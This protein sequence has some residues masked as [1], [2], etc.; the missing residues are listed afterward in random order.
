[1]PAAGGIL[2]LDLSLT[3]G[4][5]YGCLGQRPIWGVWPLGV[6]ARSGEALAVLEDHCDD[7][8]KLHRPGALVYEAPVPANRSKNGA[9]TIELLLQLCGIAKLIAVRHGI[10]YFHQHCGEARKAVLGR[11]PKGPSATIKPIIIDWARRRGWDLRGLVVGGE[12]IGVDDE[13]DALLLLQYAAVTR[14]RTGRAHFFK[15][16][17]LL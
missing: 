3:T 16:G 5:G 8:I 4:W 9:D 10:P 15:Q 11:D 13:A 12:T 6:M 7:A 1:M 2:T 14:D 17:E